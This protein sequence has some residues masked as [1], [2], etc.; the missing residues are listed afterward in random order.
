[1]LPR[2]EL[3]M[4]WRPAKSLIQLRDQINRLAP[5]RSKASDGTIGDASHQSRDSDHNPWVQDGG[6]GVVTA[7]DITHDPG[8]GCDC[9]QIVQALLISRDVRIKYIIWNRRIVSSTVQPWLWR[10]YT[11]SNPHTKHF[12][13]S[14]KSDKVHYDSQKDWQIDSFGGQFRTLELDSPRMRGGD[15]RIVQQ[16]LL[17]LGYLDSEDDVDSIYGPDT[18]TAVRKFQT[19]RGIQ[20]NGVVGDTTYQELGIA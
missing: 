11:G 18:E 6:I 8:D 13:L 3:K 17:E 15:V 2:G 9:E 12:H 20:V 5:T 16:K 1:M 4:A 19:D 10:R 7:I 14:V